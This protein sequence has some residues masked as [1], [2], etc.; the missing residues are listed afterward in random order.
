VDFTWATMGPGLKV[1]AQHKVKTVMATMWGDDGAETNHFLALSQVPMFSEF[2]WRGDE[3][4]PEVVKATGEF[5]TGLPRNAYDAFALFYPGAVDRRTGKAL[6]YCDALY[7]LG[8]QGEE[9]DLSVERSRKALEMLAPY[10]DDLFCRYASALF[11]VCY[12]KALLLQQLRPHYLAGDKTWLA[13]TA[14]ETIPALLAAYE[15]LRD[16]HKTVWERDYKRNGWEVLALRYGAVMGRLQDVQDAILRYANGELNTL[17]ELDEEPMDPT[18]K[19]GMQ[20][21]QV[22]ASP[23]CSM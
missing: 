18:R 20:W 10:Q 14:E 8:P 22:Y 5:L 17:C 21:Y 19:S 4:T 9:L 3:C 2:C 7:P 11:E 16:L 15:K 12:E 23:V 1:C 6:V 13:H